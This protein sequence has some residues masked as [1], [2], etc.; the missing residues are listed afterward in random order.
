[1]CYVEIS[2]PP[3]V[4]SVHEPRRTDFVNERQA[5]GFALQHEENLSSQAVM[6]ALFRLATCLLCSVF[7]NI[8]CIDLSSS[9]LVTHKCLFICLYAWLG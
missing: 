6:C 9:W 1:M 4:D 2:E 3:R 5:S 7:H 8:L